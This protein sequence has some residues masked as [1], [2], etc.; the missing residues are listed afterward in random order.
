MDRLPPIGKNIPNHH[1]VK[2]NKNAHLP[3]TIGKDGKKQQCNCSLCVKREYIC[4]KGDREYFSGQ[5]SFSQVRRHE[6]DHLR[7]HREIAQKL[8]LKI[9]NTNIN[10]FSEM[11]PDCNDSIATGGNASSVFAAEIDGRQV[12]VQVSSDGNIM[13]SEIAGKLEQKKTKKNGFVKEDKKTE[14]SQTEKKDDNSQDYLFF[15]V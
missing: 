3:S 12:I 10:V 4:S 2:G 11:C 14:S 15:D 1:R 13:D 8:G 9:V 5:D 7:E 6:Q